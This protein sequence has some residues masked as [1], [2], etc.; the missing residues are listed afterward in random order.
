MHNF[1]INLVASGTLNVDAK[2]H[3][4]RA[5]VCV[6]ALRHFD[7]LSD[8]VES[9]ETLTVEYIIKELELYTPPVNS[10]FLKSVLC[11]AE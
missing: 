5:I 11:P 4:L 3:Y 10:L 9:A 7:S 8:D 6:E 2:I 1:K